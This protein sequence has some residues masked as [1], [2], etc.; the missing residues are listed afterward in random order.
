MKV[1][2]LFVGRRLFVG[3]GNPVGLGIG[4]TEIRGSSYIEGPLMVGNPLT[5][6]IAEANLMVARCINIEALPPP[7]SIFKVSTRGMPPTP[8]DVMLG[9][10]A[11]HV[12]ISVNSTVISIFND[13]NISII[14]P[15]TTGVGILNWVGAKTLTGVVAETGAEARI[16]KEAVSAA[17][18]DN[19]PKNIH[20]E[21]TI[22]GRISCPWLDNELAIARASPGKGFDMHHPTKTGWR[23]THI[24]LEGPEAAVYY[25]GILKDSNLIELPDYWRG[26]VDLET[27]T[28]HLT[29][30][31]IHQELSYQIIDCGTKIKVINNAGSSINCSYIV[32]GERKDID[33]IIVE[34][35]GKIEDYPG[36]DQRSIVGYH[37]DYR[38]GIN[39]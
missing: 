18:V 24:C 2:D 19:G 38:P 37:Y 9:D 25:R 20:G 17:T 28:V 16:G 13:T 11:G 8:I 26:L 36:R 35:E 15:F 31:G 21:L 34:Y 1:P 14:S 32:Y 29:S 7:P 23:L 27:I 30:I 22:A 5:Y 12:G 10:P 6:P 33:K 39:L 3:C 4:P